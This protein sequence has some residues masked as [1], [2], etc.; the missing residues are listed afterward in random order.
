MYS[1]IRGLI[2]LDGTVAGPRAADDIQAYCLALNEYY[3]CLKLRSHLQRQTRP[4]KA[5]P[6]KSSDT[7]I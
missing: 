1:A 5:G 2:R 7:T 6:N 3:A 4:A